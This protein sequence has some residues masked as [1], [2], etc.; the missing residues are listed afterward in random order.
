MDAMI[1]THIFMK[2][3]LLLGKNP[4]TSHLM[5]TEI[6]MLEMLTGFPIFYHHHPSNNV[7]MPTS[8]NLTTGV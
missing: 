4:A 1:T 6:M 3:K 7:F 5:D 2:V 8:Q